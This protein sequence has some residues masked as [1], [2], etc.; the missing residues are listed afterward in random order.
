MP[1]KKKQTISIQGNL[2]KGIDNKTIRNFQ[3]VANSSGNPV[4]INYLVSYK[5]QDP[6]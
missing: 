1:R 6:E 4:L 5:G 3:V 2:L